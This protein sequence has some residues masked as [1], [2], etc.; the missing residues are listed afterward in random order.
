MKMDLL[1]LLNWL[2]AEEKASV[3]LKL[4]HMMCYLPTFEGKSVSSCSERQ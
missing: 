3:C 4:D 1:N 2:K